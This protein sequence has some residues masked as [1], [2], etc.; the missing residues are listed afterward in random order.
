MR[1]LHGSKRFKLFGNLGYI[2][3]DAILEEIKMA[4][5]GEASSQEPGP[6]IRYFR[7]ETVW[8]K[9]PSYQKNANEGLS[10][11]GLNWSS[12]AHLNICH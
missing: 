3:V 5:I 7:E 8:V 9:R 1:L 11:K 6:Q 12:V 10:C 4:M 2:T